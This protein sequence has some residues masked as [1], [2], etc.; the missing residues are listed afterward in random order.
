[1]S[2]SLN[3]VFITPGGVDRSGRERVIPHFLW[4][5]E[6]LSL[7]H[8]VKVISLFQ[9]DS[10]CE[11]SLNGIQ[12][13]VPGKIRQDWKTDKEPGTVLN[14]LYEACIA[15]LDPAEPVDIVHGLWGFQ[16]G[17]IATRIA[18]SLKIPSVV[19]LMGAEFVSFPD[20]KYGGQYWEHQRLTL[21]DTL[22]NATALTVASHFMQDMASAYSIETDY[23]PFGVHESCFQD[24]GALDI[25]TWRLLTVASINRIKDF[26]TLIEAFRIVVDEINDV[27]LDIIGED[28]M[29]E[30]IQALSDRLCLTNHVN[31]HGFLPNDEIRKYFQRAHLY[32]VTSINET[33]PIAM[34]EAAAC[35]VATVGT[36]VGYV[37][38][39]DGKRSL[40]VESQ[41]PGKLAVQ[42]IYL[43]KHEPVRK[44]LGMAAYKWVREY[45]VNWTS[46]RL[47]K[48]YLDLINNH[49]D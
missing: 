46:N 17:W 41:S 10:A 27:Q 7:N 47:T 14:D 30:E 38:D 22:K 25:P 12:I 44:N 6:K 2:P 35:K 24:N 43:I 36:K 45:D 15:Y 26:F 28:V 33:G 31:F 39:W 3:I 32:V 42:I 1:M 48:L 16:A 19:S 29:D 49:M 21:N 5:L 4:L 40:A 37:S 9:Y 34:L 23:I 8:N 20:I 18:S 11:Y 13:S